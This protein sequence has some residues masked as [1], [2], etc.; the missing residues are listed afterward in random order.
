SRIQSGSPLIFESSSMTS[1][2][3][4]FLAT[5]CPCSFSL[6]GLG[7]AMRVLSVAAI[8]R[9]SSG[10]AGFSDPSGPRYSAP[11]VLATALAVLA[12]LPTIPGM[13]EWHAAQG[14]F[15]P[16]G[17]RPQITL[18]L[19]SHDRRLGREG[20]RLRA[21]SGARAGAEISA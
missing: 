7:F 9:D 18:A 1:R 16:Y 15:D 10:A 12:A 2:D 11:G 6:I 14:T 13:R 21:R 3:M 5:S 20:Y 8:P 17:A 19:G 4:P